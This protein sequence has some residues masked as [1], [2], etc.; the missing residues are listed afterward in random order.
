[1]GEREAH[2]GDNAPCSADVWLEV[3]RMLAGV[4]GGGVK[5]MDA[6]PV[7]AASASKRARDEACK[8]RWQ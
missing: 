3:A 5:G 1:M 2:W 7:M 4:L 6:A 8:A